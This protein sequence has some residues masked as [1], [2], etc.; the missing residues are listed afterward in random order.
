MNIHVFRFPPGT[1]L[2]QELQHIT[3]KNNL[4]TACIF[5][6]VG[7]LSKATLRM[8][9]AS[10]RKENIRTYDEELEIVSAAGTL[11]TDGL[12]VHLGPRAQR[13]VASVDTQKTVA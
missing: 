4:Q 12:H 5:T 2:K 9:G 11:G 6:C 7:S 8:A 3:K 13:E 10:A 1:D